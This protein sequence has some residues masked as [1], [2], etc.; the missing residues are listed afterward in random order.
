MCAYICLSIHVYM[1]GGSNSRTVKDVARRFL[2]N[3]IYVACDPW[4][5]ASF[6][7]FMLFMSHWMLKWPKAC[8][9]LSR[10]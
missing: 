5:V 4:S 8:S 10:D 2:L 3:I 9:I 7:L 6:Q 1:S